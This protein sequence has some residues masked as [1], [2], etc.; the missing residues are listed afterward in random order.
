M[1]FNGVAFYLQGALRVSTRLTGRF[2]V[3]HGRFVRLSVHTHFLAWGSHA[4]ELFQ[5]VP[6]GWRRIGLRQFRLLSRRFII[7]VSHGRRCVVGFTRRKGL[8]NLRDGPRVCP[9]FCS[10]GVSVSLCFPRILMVRGCVVFGRAIFGLSLKGRRVFTGN[11]VRPVAPPRVVT[12][13]G[14][15]VNCFRPAPAHGLHAGGVGRKF[16]FGVWERLVKRNLVCL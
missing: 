9:L 15:A 16:S 1:N 8:V 7:N 13:Y 3:L 10:H 2:F 6:H 4:K 14:M 12:F 5:R 11:V